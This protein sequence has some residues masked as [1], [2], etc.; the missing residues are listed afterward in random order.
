LTRV[1]QVKRLTVTV[2]QTL[3]CA[4]A[5]Q[6]QVYRRVV[7]PSAQPAPSFAGLGACDH[8]VYTAGEELLLS[9]LAELDLTRARDFFEL[10][11]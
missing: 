2:L 5:T 10:R 9:P 11:Y 3:N 4:E 1:Q 7:I 8:L 6:L